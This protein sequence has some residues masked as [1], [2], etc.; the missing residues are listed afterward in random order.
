MSTVSCQYTVSDLPLLVGGVG[1]HLVLSVGG[2]GS[3]Q[4]QGY[5]SL[6]GMGVG[7]PH[8]GSVVGRSPGNKG[9]QLLEAR[10]RKTEELT[11][12]ERSDV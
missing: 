11:D 9:R 8:D 12:G 3:Q 4:D 7:E 10:R 6:D 2:R 5:Q 1:L